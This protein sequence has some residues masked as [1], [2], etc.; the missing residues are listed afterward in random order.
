MGGAVGVGIVRT[1]VTMPVIL[2]GGRFSE[3][4]V[5]AEGTRDVMT[6][7]EGRVQREGGGRYG[8]VAIWA[9]RIGWWSGGSGPGRRTAGRYT[10]VE[11]A[12]TL[13]IRRRLIA[14][15]RDEDIL[16]IFETRIRWVQ[17]EML[18]VVT[19]HIC[20]DELVLA[21]LTALAR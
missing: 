13:R 11:R 12:S 17:N 2:P 3:E 19:G 8:K 10:V 20:E 1:D 15:D 18:R 21:R 16:T 6:G 14:M 4:D 5:M 7:A 9:K